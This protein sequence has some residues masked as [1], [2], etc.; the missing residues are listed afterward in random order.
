MT[1]CHTNLKRT[2]AAFVVRIARDY[3]MS[4]GYQVGKSACR[5]RALPT[6]D[7]LPSS[8]SS[9]STSTRRFSSFQPADPPGTHGT[10]V[11]PD[12]DFSVAS[13]TSSDAIRR[14]NDPNSVFV[15]TGANR[16]IGFQFV[17]SLIDRTEV[18]KVLTTLCSNYTFGL[19]SLLTLRIC[20]QGT[21]VA[22]CRS[23]ESATYLTE[24][25]SSLDDSSRIH[26]V[27][28]DV[29]DQA[30]IERAGS[31]IRDKF[32]R[33]DLLLNV[34]GI[35]GDAKTTPGPERSLAKMD[36]KWFEKTLAVNLIGPVMFSKELSPAMMH[37]R[38]RKVEGDDDHGR[39][40]AVIAN[41]S[42]RVGSI[43]DNG[44]GGWYSY[45]MSKSA[46][47]QAT[48]TMALELK[49]HSVWTVAVHPGTTDTGL[50]KPFQGNVKDGS[51]FPV[52]FTVTKLLNVIDAMQEENSGGFYDW[53]GKA[54]SF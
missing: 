12:I 13:G 36:R 20:F 43:S 37:P 47:N 48:R 15:V 50:S 23:P 52:E 32:N 39:P 3:N 34:A 4:L 16:G 41:L 19:F 6:R 18:R 31:A 26:I 44:L 45:R 40:T 49:R 54:I 46:L 33:V 11:F 8:S 9:S 42:A 24:F 28:L 30:S 2:C 21:V 29:E 51:L 14:N 10:P 27:P 7:C 17:K 38:R 25:A 5:F 22:C 53:A 1:N 35:L